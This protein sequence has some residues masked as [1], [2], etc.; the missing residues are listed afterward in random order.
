MSHLNPNFLTSSEAY[1]QLVAGSDKLQRI[2]RHSKPVVASSSV[3]DVAS[4]LRTVLV[5]AAMWYRVRRLFLLCHQIVSTNQDH[6]QSYLTCTRSSTERYTGQFVD[7]MRVDDF[8]SRVLSLADWSDFHRQLRRWNSMVDQLSELWIL[9]EQL[10][11]VDK[12]QYHRW[13]KAKLVPIGGRDAISVLLCHG[14]NR[15]TDLP[16]EH[17]LF[18]I[19]QVARRHEDRDEYN[20]LALSRQLRPIAE[21]RGPCPSM[22]R[23][24]QLL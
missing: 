3:A 19:C 24:R 9:S 17:M 18:G 14:I 8:S 23:G 7:T 4:Q 6:L 21:R 11:F 22:S 16:N 1:R 13:R 10:V 2:I 15:A 12:D 20:L 5:V